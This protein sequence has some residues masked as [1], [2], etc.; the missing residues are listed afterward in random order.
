MR[1]RLVR[2]EYWQDDTIGHM[3]DSVRLFYIGLWCAADDAGWLEWKPSQLGASLYPYRPTSTRV[4][5]IKTWG[6][7][8]VA[9]GK[10]VIHPC[11]CAFIPTFAKHQRLGGNASFQYREKHRYHVA[12][13]DEESRQIHTGIA[14]GEVGR[15]KEGEV[16]KEGGAGPGAEPGRAD[17]EQKVVEMRRHGQRERGA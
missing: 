4:R 11:G 17:W 13:T 6:D 14:R 8:L 16:G 9:A 10:L 1:I 7:G 15:G 3:S 12:L 2:P 5:N